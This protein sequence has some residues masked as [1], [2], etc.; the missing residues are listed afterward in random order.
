[1]KKDTKQTR[2]PVVDV[3]APVNW[4]DAFGKPRSARSPHDYIALLLDGVTKNIC[5]LR[6]DGS[7]DG[8]TDDEVQKVAHDLFDAVRRLI[9]QTEA[10]GESQEREADKMSGARVADPD[11]RAR[12][13]YAYCHEAE[14]A[15]NIGDATAAWT[16]I[17]D[18][19]RVAADIKV[20]VVHRAGGVYRASID[21]KKANV[22]SRVERR[23]ATAETKETVYRVWCEWNAGKRPKRGESLAFAMECLRRLKGTD[24]SAATIKNKWISEF[25]KRDKRNQCAGSGND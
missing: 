4:L 13:V 15:F 5:L 19:M 21:G 11:E 22:A 1:M 9:D 14:L 6:A 25:K 17:V 18:A 3:P 8:C 12:I 23:Y 16:L 7:K 2:K 20:P 10:T 24:V